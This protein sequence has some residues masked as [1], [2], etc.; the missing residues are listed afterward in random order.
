MTLGLK[1]LRAAGRQRAR[2]LG[3]AMP[4]AEVAA[5]LAVGAAALAWHPAIGLWAL[6]IA[7][8]TL[9]ARHGYA[10]G[11]VTGLGAAG[12]MLAA[13]GADP[14]AAFDLGGQH[15]AMAEACGL[16]VLGGAVGL[17]GD[18]QRRAARRQAMAIATLHD[19]L[20]T[21]TGRH[22]ALE[23]EKA[24]TDRRL[25]RQ[26]LPLE[27]FERELAGLRDM[28]PQA[29]VTGVLFLLGQHA[30]IGAAALYLASPETGGWRLAGALGDRRE[31]AINLHAEDNLQRSDSPG[32]A[33]VGAMRAPLVGA[34][35]RCLGMLVAEEVAF[36]QG[37]ATTVRML[38]RAATHLATALPLSTVTMG[39]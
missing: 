39:V 18:A 25:A 4:W 5:G 35:G 11:A 13:A 29:L 7:T 8:A 28:T 16:G 31:R 38:E 32:W 23:A 37:N 14:L 30:A 27:A 10:E 12:L 20:R 26:V 22:R 3:L 1:R 17:V 15:P 6:V 33:A 2:A 19:E 34:D 36:D 24:A 9:A 21:L